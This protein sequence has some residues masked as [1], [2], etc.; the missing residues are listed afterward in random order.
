MVLAFAALIWAYAIFLTGGFI[1]DVGFL[2]VS[3]RSER[4]PLIASLLAAV[5]AWVLTP[6]GQRRQVW[7]LDGSRVAQHIEHGIEAVSTRSRLVGRVLAGLLASATVALGILL[8]A[9]VAGGADSYAYLSQARLWGAGT[10]RVEQPLIKDLPPGIM[11]EALAPLGYRLSPDRTA[12]VPVFPPGLPML[13]AVFERVG[14]PTAMFLVMPLLAGLSV[15]AAYVLGTTL[16]GPLAGVLAALLIATSPAFVFQVTHAPMSD[17]AAAGWWASV[18]ILLPRV[19]RSSAL[20][21]GLATGAAI[22]TRPNLVPLAVVPGCLLLWDLIAD[23]VSR[24]IAVQRLLLFAAA[25]IPAC[26]VIALL[27]KLWYGSPLQSGYGALAGAFFQWNHGWPNLQHYWRWAMDSQ[28]PLIVVAVAAPV[29]VWRHL[30]ASTGR[31]LLV[32]MVGF[33]LGVYACYAFY[34]PFDDWWF[35]RFLLPAFPASFALMSVALVRLCGPLPG[36]VR[37]MA[38]VILVALVVSHSIQFGRAHSAYHSAPEWR[39]ATVGEHIA[40]HLPEDAIFVASLH[41]GSARY[42]S[43]RMT[44]RYDFIAA[45]QL[46]AVLAH[47]E[48]AGYSA[49]ILL[50]D[51]EAPGFISNFSGHSAVGALDWPPIAD[52]SGVKIYA[53][54]AKGR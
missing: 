29:L 9:H 47:V 11:A 51:L 49:Y 36:H 15:Y 46:D 34:L 12:L 2:R 37:W 44:I 33:V 32:V 42:Y 7:L 52:V 45:E 25:S 31:P 26:V 28:T 30:S 3:S 43:G 24:R 54:S 22:L 21:A 19:S 16:G 17:I 50:D 1:L 10:L 6:A 8:G 53:T 18:L 20:V 48:R 14:G 4:N 39:F 35:L 27:N 38:P 41:S 40:A 13:M 5:A 23:R